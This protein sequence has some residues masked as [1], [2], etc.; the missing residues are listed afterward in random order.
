M[1][2]GNSDFGSVT[3]NNSEFGENRYNQLTGLGRSLYVGRTQNLTVENSYFHSVKYG[4]EIERV[5]QYRSKIVHKR[6]VEYSF[7]NL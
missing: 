3:F 1:L 5:E 6:F 4:H 7:M 2:T